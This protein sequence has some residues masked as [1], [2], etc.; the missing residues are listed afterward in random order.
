MNGKQIK[1]AFDELEANNPLEKATLFIDVTKKGG[2]TFEL[3]VRSG[4]YDLFLEDE[5]LVLRYDYREGDVMPFTRTPNARHL[6]VSFIPFEQ[7][8]LIEL[9]SKA[10]VME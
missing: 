4:A 10:E 6:G 8:K 3:T 7:I 5:L 9:E 1:T 2:E